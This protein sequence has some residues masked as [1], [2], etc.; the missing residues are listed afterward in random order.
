LAAGP[1]TGQQHGLAA[2]VH[3][4]PGQFVDAIRV[5]AVRCLDQVAERHRQGLGDQ[6]EGG[7]ADILFTRFYCHQHASADTGFFCKGALAQLCRMAQAP[8]ILAHVLKHGGPLTGIFVHY[9]AHS[10]DLRS[11][12][13]TFRRIVRRSPHVCKP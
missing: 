13:P 3:T 8:D 10:H 5:T 4:G 7:Q 9:I 2:G 11:I 1:G 6:V 12:L